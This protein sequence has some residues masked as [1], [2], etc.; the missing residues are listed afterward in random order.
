MT[1]TEFALAGGPLHSNDATKETNRAEGP[2]RE[3]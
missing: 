3:V 2:E 1:G